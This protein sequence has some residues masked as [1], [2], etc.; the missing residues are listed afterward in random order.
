MGRN[1]FYVSQITA[2]VKLLRTTLVCNL[3]CISV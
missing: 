1:L 3:K 2:H